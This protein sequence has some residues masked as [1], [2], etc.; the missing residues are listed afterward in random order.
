MVGRGAAH[1]SCSSA[2]TT[3]SLTA[4]ARPCAWRDVA[5][6]RA[7]S[8]ATFSGVVAA[9][10]VEVAAQA[11]VVV[12]MLSGAPPVPRQSA[13]GVLIGVGGPDRVHQLVVVA[14]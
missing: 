5:A 3:G 11:A 14:Q 2:S 9:E 1:N 8:V 4:G 6:R 12:L 7:P 13:G 10:M